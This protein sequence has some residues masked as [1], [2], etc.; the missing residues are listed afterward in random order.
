MEF[1]GR[2]LAERWDGRPTFVL[3]HGAHANS[4]AWAGVVRELALLGHR[5][6]AVD[7]PGH[8]IDACFPVSYQ[9]P[10]DLVALAGQVSPL[11]HVT[12]DDNVD[13]V[14]AAVRRVAQYGPVVLAGTSGGGATI[15]GVG[16]AV[17]ELLARIVYISAWCCVSLPSVAAYLATLGH[18]DVAATMVNWRTAD[19]STLAALKEGLMADASDDQFRACL[20]TLEPADSVQVL[21]AD[22]RVR[23]QTWGRIPRTY[24]RFARDRA[25]PIDVQDKM[26]A[27]ADALTPDNVFD[28]HTIDT[29]H[30]GT[31]LRPRE[32]AAI[33]DGLAV[34]EGSPRGTVVR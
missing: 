14:E 34:I 31:Y 2:G 23:A 18:Y 6:V 13:H 12:L 27:E 3:V 17:P 21:T 26:I 24:I 11:A 33:L 19:A 4:S 32:I 5:A 28:V 10:Q 9:S 22:S 15:S 7:L 16:N 29:S 30:M 25:I 8:G 1:R 20:N